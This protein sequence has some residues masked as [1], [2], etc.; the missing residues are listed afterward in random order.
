[1]EAQRWWG[2]ARAAWQGWQHAALEW[3]GK[4]YYEYVPETPL[5]VSFYVALPGLVST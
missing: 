4:K 3:Q 5:R 1:M 2:K